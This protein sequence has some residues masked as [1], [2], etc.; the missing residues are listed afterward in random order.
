MSRRRRLRWGRFL[1]APVVCAGLLAL[2]MAG[3]FR[4][5]LKPF[6]RYYLT[7]YLESSFHANQPGATTEVRCLLKIAPGRKPR[8]MLPEDGE[9]A[10][11]GNLPVQLSGKALREGWQS[12]VAGPPE[13]VASSELAPLLQRAFYPNETLSWML[14][15]AFL[16]SAMLLAAVFVYGRGAWRRWGYD[17][18]WEY[19]ERR[20][21]WQRIP[22]SKW[23]QPASKPARKAPAIQRRKAAKPA[24]KPVPATEISNSP[25]SPETP[26]VAQTALPLFDTPADKPKEA[27]VWDKSKGIE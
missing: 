4:V 17:V 16:A 7:A 24:A 22:W 3:W 9:A 21:A 26:A 18:I 25:P 23:F 11:E 12:V 10:T 20:K 5:T 8:I 2:T 19:R 13:R 1:A 27:F 14:I 15:E 6:Q